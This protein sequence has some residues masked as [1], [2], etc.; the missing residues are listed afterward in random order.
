MLG[1]GLCIVAVILVRSF[2][3]LR[4]VILTFPL[5]LGGFRFFVLLIG[6]YPSY[7]LSY[8]GVCLTGG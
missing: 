7:F 3:I 5:S 8:R 4:Q 6:H 1:T 2:C